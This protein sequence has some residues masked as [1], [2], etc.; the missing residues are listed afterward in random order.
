MNWR[1]AKDNLITITRIDCNNANLKINDEFN[2][3]LEILVYDNK[4]TQNKEG[5]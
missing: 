5:Q 4:E 2:V 3:S 1:S